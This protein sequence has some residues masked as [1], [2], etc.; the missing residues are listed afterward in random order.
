MFKWIC[1]LGL[2]SWLIARNVWSVK[3]P[4]SLNDLSF[5]MS[6]T[7]VEDGIS[8]EHPMPV[9][10]TDQ[11]NT[12]RWTISLPAHLDYP[13]KP[14]EYADICHRSDDLARRLRHL[15][16]RSAFQQTRGSQGYYYDVD[17]NFMD[18]REA[19][20]HG[21]LPA[22][23]DRNT[24]VS[25]GNS[26]TKELVTEGWKVKYAGGKGKICERSL[27]YVLE[28]TDAGIGKTLMGLWLAY[29]LAKKEDRAFFIDDAH[30]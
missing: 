12:P 16:G 20:E 5:N 27:T 24:I 8:L 3:T 2:I 21:L 19:V 7:L 1:G 9:V 17:P 29:G 22:G 14:S 10:V 18:I 4:P 6:H 28:T 11:Q 13:L 15:N 26:G 30:W 23:N 25:Q